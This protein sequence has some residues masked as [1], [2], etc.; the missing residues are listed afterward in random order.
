M[1]TSRSKKQK[2]IPFFRKKA[3]IWSVGVVLGLVILIALAFRLSPYPGVF[4]I[5]TV[6]DQDA[7]KTRVA[8]EKHETAAP[9]TV[10]TDQQYIDGDADAK[11]DV[12]IPDE[13]VAHGATLP[14]VVW[15]HGG[16]WIS[17][18]KSNAGPYFKLLAEKG[19]VVISLNYTLAPDKVYPAQVQQLN[20]AHAYIQAHADRFHINPRQVVLAGDSAGAQLSS[21]IVTIITNPGYAKEV[22]IT[23]SLPA[24]DLA[25]VVL[26]CGIYKM[27]GLTHPDADLS[28]LVNWGDDVTVWAYTGSRDKQDPVIRQMSAYYHVDGNFPNTFISGGNADPLTNAQSVPLAEKLSSLGVNVTTLFYEADHQPGLPH[29]YQFNLDTDD[30]AAA[31]QRLGDFLSTI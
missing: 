3:F 7:Q 31:L 1:G 23:P 16:A 6:F 13:R 14:A 25:A 8:L 2:R 20:A 10:L 26:F 24:S 18:D 15:T 5:R 29:E 19:Y 11:L 17:G 22:Q 21:Q 4:I 12:Y 9:I 27:E 28:K 30:G